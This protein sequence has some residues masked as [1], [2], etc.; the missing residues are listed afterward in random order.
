M[1]EL[2]EPMEGDFISASQQQELVRQAR[3]KIVGPGV[4]T[5]SEGIHIREPKRIS[6]ITVVVVSRQ[7]QNENSGD[8]SFKVRR[9]RNVWSNTDPPSLLPGRYEWDGEPFD[10]YSDY[11]YE[12]IE[13]EPYYWDIDED[14][15]PD[16]RAVFFRT[17]FEQG[18]W[19]VDMVSGAVRADKLVVI[20]AYGNDDEGRPSE[21]SESLFV[22]EVHKKYDAWHK[23]TGEWTVVGEPVEVDVWGNMKAGDFAPFIW[24]PGALNRFATLLPLRFILGDWWVVPQF[25]EAVSVR[26]GPL[27]IVDCGEWEGG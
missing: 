21:L 10:A 15:I 2:Y 22:Q 27:Q 14:G 18:A 3:R 4:T 1:T 8:Y 6:A 5:T 26:R 7:S 12:P 9:V 23:W 17:R 11:G 16:S 25:K 24:Y 13:Y 19:I 20:R